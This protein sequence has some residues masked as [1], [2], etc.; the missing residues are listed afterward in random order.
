MMFCEI[1]QNMMFVNNSTGEK[2]E[3]ICKNCNN[4]VIDNI[5]GT[6]CL[7][8]TIL[9]EDKN[10]VKIDKTIK[11]DPT[12][13]RVDFIICPNEA[14]TVEENKV[15]YMKTNN[16]QMK[17]T[18]FCCDCETFWNTNKNEKHI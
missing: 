7:S 15:I 13:P 10:N 16:M 3:Y 12:L 11:Y 6:K 2:L 5:V 18:Y 4:H 8:E 1:C 14:C 17:F 9:T